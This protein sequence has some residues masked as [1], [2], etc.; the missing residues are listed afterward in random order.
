M[1]DVYILNM[2]QNN[3]FIYRKRSSDD[4]GYL[5][6]VKDL[7]TENSIGFSH[8]GKDDKIVFV[9]EHIKAYVGK[10]YGELRL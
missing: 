6:T 3:F 10:N 8:W 5:R 9:P 2:T 1:S 4:N 7:T